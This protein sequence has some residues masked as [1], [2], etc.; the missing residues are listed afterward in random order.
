M[1]CTSYIQHQS[2]PTASHSAPAISVLV[3]C[4]CCHTRLLSCYLVG[5]APH[6]HTDLQGCVLAQL[7]AA[8]QR[9]ATAGFLMNSTPFLKLVPASLSP[10]SFF[11]SAQQQQAKLVSRTGLSRQGC[12]LDSYGCP[13]AMNMCTWSVI[14]CAVLAAVT[15]MPARQQQQAAYCSQL[16]GAARSQHHHKHSDCGHFAS[17][18]PAQHTDVSCSEDCQAGACSMDSCGPQRARHPLLLAS[19]RFFLPRPLACTMPVSMASC[20]C[21]ASTLRRCLAMPTPGVAGRGRPSGELVGV[22]GCCGSPAGQAQL[23]VTSAST[24]LLRAQHDHTT[25][26]PAL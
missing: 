4:G 15:S 21:R 25:A 24:G 11:S 26:A 9:L 18:L 10:G 19:L 20:S 7:A 14:Y 1:G 23:Q 5:E 22:H 16:P 3:S 13:R 12:G 2:Q 17:C 8:P 6:D